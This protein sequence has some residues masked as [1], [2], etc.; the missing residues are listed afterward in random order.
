MAFLEVIR[1]GLWRWAL[2]GM[3]VPSRKAKDGTED[4]TREGGG[5]LKVEPTGNHQK[6]P[7]QGHY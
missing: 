2:A 4:K 7:H 3:G 1:E 6:F 5:K